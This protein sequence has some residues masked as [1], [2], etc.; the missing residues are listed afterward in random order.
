MKI[1]YFYSAPIYVSNNTIG[2]IIVE[3]VSVA[4][5]KL[6]ILIPVTYLIYYLSN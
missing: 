2:G 3:G 4:I 5:Q 6:A 1:F